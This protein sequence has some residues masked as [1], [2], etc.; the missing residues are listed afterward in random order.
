LEPHTLADP[1]RRHLLAALAGGPLPA[2]A[3]ADDLPVTRSAVSQQ[4]AI[5]RQAGLVTATKQGREMFYARV[6]SAIAPATDWVGS[7][8]AFQLE[9]A[10]TR[11]H[12]ASVTVPVADQDRALG[13]YVGRC[14]FTVVNDRRQPDGFRWISVAPPGGACVL[15]LVKSANTG[16][17]TG[18]TFITADIAGQYE[19]WLHRGVSFEAPP[20]RPWGALS[21]IFSDIDGNRHQ[22]AELP[23]SEGTAP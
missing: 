17:W 8:R 10:A 9:R 1:I 3:L 18:I 16:V 4:L 5:L 2:H 6:E 20:A 13:F 11:L 12:I 22:L 23:P 21:T 14:G 19:T 7:F 15:G